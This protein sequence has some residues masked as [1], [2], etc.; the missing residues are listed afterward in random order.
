MLFLYVFALA[1]FFS[2]ILTSL[3]KILAY[4]TGLVDI[5]NHRKIHKEPVAKI[6]GIAIFLS[7]TLSIFWLVGLPIIPIL[8][9]ASIILVV[10][11]LDDIMEFSPLAKI[12]GQVLAAVVLVGNGIKIGLLPDMLSIPLTLF[13]MLGIMNALNLIDGMDGMA[14]GVSTVAALFF[15][16]LAMGNNNVPLALMAIALAGAC[17]GFLK[18]NFH[19]ASIFMG[20]TGS[21]FLGFILA[22]LG[23]MSTIKSSS[24]VHL[25][26]PIFILGVPIFDTLLAI[27]RRIIKKKPLFNADTDHFYEWLWKNK[28]L[29]YNTVVIST[30]FLSFLLGLMALC[31]GWKYG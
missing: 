7:F 12:L 14:A 13:W 24:F 17:L 4:R 19:Q 5:P 6:G 8:F 9:G 10:G 16:V 28:I 1:L 2:L 3:V 11:F 25:L 22:F 26:L 23:V 18:F 30:Y 20:D 27:F 29:G 21:L 31:I 15:M